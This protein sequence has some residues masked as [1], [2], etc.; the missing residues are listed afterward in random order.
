M[1]VNADSY[2]KAKG[3]LMM[4]ACL[5]V[6]PVWLSAQRTCNRQSMVTAVATSSLLHP[7]DVG[8]EIGYGQYVLR[9]FWCVSTGAIMQSL[10]TDSGFTMKYLDLSCSGGYMHRLVGTRSR[11]INLYAGGEA[12]LGFETY[13]PMNELPST[14]D[15]GLP[16]GSFIY[17]ISPQVV[18]EFFLAGRLAL[19]AGCSV[20]VNLSSPITKI[21]PKFNLGLRLNI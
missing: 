10:A 12:F 9:G 18:A 11:N 8:A 3:F 1:F 17:G 15:T 21:R 6:C 16:S 14:I 5:F 13:D 19:V 20:P 4:L 7:Q 2:Q